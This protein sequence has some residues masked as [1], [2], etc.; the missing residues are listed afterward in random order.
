MEQRSLNGNPAS[1]GRTRRYQGT[2]VAFRVPR[3]RLHLK[4]GS[5]MGCC[6]SSFRP[7]LRHKLRRERPSH[8]RQGKLARQPVTGPPATTAAAVFLFPI[9]SPTIAASHD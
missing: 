4:A 1:G 2:R 6:S 9:T 3:S 5:G 7:L 8:W